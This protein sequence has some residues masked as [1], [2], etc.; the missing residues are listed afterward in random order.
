MLKRILL[1][2]DSSDSG[3]VAISF[4]IAVADR[5]T[6]VRILHVNELLLG[7][8]GQTMETPTEA[9]FLLDDA[10][11]QLRCCGVTATGVMATGVVATATSFAVAECIIAEADRWSADAIVLGS[12][13]RRGLRRIASQGVRERVIR[14]SCLPV[15]AAPAPLRVASADLAPE[16]GPPPGRRGPISRLHQ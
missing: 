6:E 8:R 3:Q 7:G 4:T 14:F 1:A 15:L 16:M 10:V 13:R 5:D 11:L 9:R 2:L 12:A